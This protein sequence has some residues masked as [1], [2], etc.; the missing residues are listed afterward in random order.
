M[1][2]P[3][4]HLSSHDVGPVPMKACKSPLWVIASRSRWLVLWR[5]IC[6]VIL[7]LGM[8][9]T[10]PLVHAA[11]QFGT[12]Q[13]LTPDDPDDTAPQTAVQPTISLEWTP[14]V[15]VVIRRTTGGI[16]Q[17]RIRLLTNLGVQIENPSGQSIDLPKSAIKTLRLP[18]FSLQFTTKDDPLEETIRKWANLFNE[19]RST[20]HL[21]NESAAGTP[22]AAHAMPARTEPARTEPGSTQIAEPVAPVENSAAVASV[23]QQPMTPPA[24]QGITTTQ[25][26]STTQAPLVPAST[27]PTTTTIS[28][29]PPPVYQSAPVQGSATPV[30]AWYPA[31]GNSP[32][33]IATSGSWS[34]G[35]YL[36]I[37]LA[38]AL[39]GFVV[40]Q[41]RKA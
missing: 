18:D 39:V 9:A 41:S 8:S 20:L 7:A 3:H 13:D 32:A 29:N 10:N 31:A 12:P 30:T 11:P 25:G 23:S 27:S 21:A 34:L 17:G 33:P 22:G 24:A 28:A 6:L 4:R 16:L 36:A 1:R 15:N 38:A 19:G 37:A 40:F 2:S 14:P 26:I 35:S 5:S